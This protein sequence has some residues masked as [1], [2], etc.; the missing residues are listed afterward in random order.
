MPYTPNPDD[1]SAPVESVLAGTAAAE[2]RA[3]KSKVNNL[4]LLGNYDSDLAQQ[5][6]KAGTVLVLDL[7]AT[8][9][10]PAWATSGGGIL[11]GHAVNITRNDIAVTGLG[12]GAHVSAVAAQLTA[13]QG[14]NQNST[15]VYIFGCATEAWTS[16]VNSQAILIGLETSVISQYNDNTC[17]LVGLDVVFKNR[18]DG[19]NTNGP[20]AATAMVAGITYVIKVPGTTVWTNFGAANNLAG[21]V[22]VATGPGTGTG[23]CEGAVRQGLGANH[24]NVN[25][26]AVQITAMAPSGV[27]E[28]AG[29]HKGITFEVNSI[30]QAL[31][32]GVIVPGLVI[33]MTNMGNPVNVAAYNNPWVAYRHSAALALSEYM[34]IT[35]DKLQFTRTFLD[36]FNTIM[37]LFAIGGNS[38][39]PTDVTKC[40]G[41]D[42]TNNYLVMPTLT[43]GGAPGAPTGT[44][45]MKVGGVVRNVHFS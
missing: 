2:F 21:T 26:R 39:T 32:G 15:N 29:W 43:I 30:S 6:L 44:F 36:S 19:Y 8:V 13:I 18:P 20:I 23:T 37:W 5:G 22:F 10:D 40:V 24:Y 31:I 41:F 9:F 7:P 3:F 35:W 11:Y 12:A 25:S 16:P 4:F 27:G 42:Y 1:A 34:S 33:D 28:Y 14:N 38:T 17:A 45:P